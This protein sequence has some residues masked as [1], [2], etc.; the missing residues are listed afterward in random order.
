VK[1]TQDFRTNATTKLQERDVPTMSDV[2]IEGS[3]AKT[4]G[5]T[6]VE[7]QGSDVTIE[8]AMEE[9]QMEMFDSICFVC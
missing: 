5:F 1:K 6:I 9:I 4:S 2:A 8:V 7:L 3:I